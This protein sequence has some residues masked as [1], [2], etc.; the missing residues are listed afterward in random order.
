MALADVGQGLGAV[1][2]VLPARKST[3][4]LLVVCATVTSMPPTESTSEVNPAKS[5]TPKWSTRTPVSFSTVSM[6]SGAP[7]KA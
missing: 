1:E 2:V 6:S 4:A 3:P 7:P 5:T